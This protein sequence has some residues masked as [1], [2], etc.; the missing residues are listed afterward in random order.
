MIS[1]NV[2]LSISSFSFSVLTVEVESLLSGTFDDLLDFL[3]GIK[4]GDN[5]L[6]D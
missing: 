4:D 3:R 1:I 2:L 6:L 5:K